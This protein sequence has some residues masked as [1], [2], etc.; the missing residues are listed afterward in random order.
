MGAN[1][2]SLP[3]YDAW[4]T[5]YPPWYDYVGYECR[6]CGEWIE[7]DENGTICPKCE[8]YQEDEAENE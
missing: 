8:E 4:K 3:G 2:Y 7:G 1:D 5:A 6:V